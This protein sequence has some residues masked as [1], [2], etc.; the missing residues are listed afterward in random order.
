MM[1]RILC[2][3]DRS[4]S[5]LQAFDYA[6]ALARW[7]GARLHLMEVVEAPSR[8]SVPIE[9][10]KTLERDLKRVLVAR[11]VSDVKVDISLRQGNVVQE[12]LAQAKESRSNLVVIGSHGHGSVHRLALGSIAEKVLRLSTSPVLTVRRGVRQRRR[13]RSRPPFETILCPTDFSEGANSAVGY[14]KLLAKEANAKLILMTAVEWPVA[15]GATSGP[16]AELRKSIEASAHDQLGRLSPRRVS[17]SRGAETVVASGKASAAIV[18]L[19]RLQSVD[20]I[21]MGISGRRA[22]DIALLGSTTY[23]VIREGVWPVL[24]VPVVER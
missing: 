23:H 2:P 14:A 18:E 5:S 4:P 1:K 8:H 16:M 3:V 10:R 19:A 22:L 15:D 12:I 7:Q 17:D 6:I 13:G 24:T 9:S 11:R 20:L 21:V